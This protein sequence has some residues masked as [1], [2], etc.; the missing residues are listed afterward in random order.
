M[1]SCLHSDICTFSFHPLKTITT[2]E[3]GMVTTDNRAIYNKMRSMREFGKVKKGIYTNY[4]TSIGYNWRLG[5][6]NSLMGLMQLRNIKKFISF[7]SI[8]ISN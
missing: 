7:K 5:E 1:C 8:L 2:G 3:G 6:V 4:H